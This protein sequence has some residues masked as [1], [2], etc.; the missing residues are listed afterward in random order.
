VNA[1]EKGR[2]YVAE[3]RLIVRHLDEHA[4]VVQADCRGDGA[5]WTLGY[6]PGRGWWCSCPAYSRCAHL[7]ALGLVVALEPREAS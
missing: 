7:H 1:A 6:E 5:V 3:G 2:A 4:G